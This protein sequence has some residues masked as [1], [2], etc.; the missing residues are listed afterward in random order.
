MSPP[1]ITSLISTEV[2]TKGQAK[3]LE[4]H[5]QTIRGPRDGT[6]DFVVLHSLSGGNQTRIAHAFVTISSPDSFGSEWKYQRSSILGCTIIARAE[7]LQNRLTLMWLRPNRGFPVHP[8][9]WC[10]PHE[11]LSQLVDQ[12]HRG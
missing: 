1:H 10:D 2:Q 11:F 6:G 4:N 7:I 8:A 12:F 9:L 5:D 3:R